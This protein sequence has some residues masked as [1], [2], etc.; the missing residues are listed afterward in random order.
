MHLANPRHQLLL[1]LVLA[2]DE[3]VADR[4]IEWKQTVDNELRYMSLFFVLYRGKYLSM[5]HFF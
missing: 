2:K 1:K 5:F 3:E 4:W